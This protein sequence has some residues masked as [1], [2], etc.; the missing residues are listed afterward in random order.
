MY[1]VPENDLKLLYSLA[2]EYEDMLRSAE[3]EFFS[4]E[5]NEALDT[6]R[7]ILGKDE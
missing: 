4:S 7:R 3:S 2:R 5:E 1:Q 6:V